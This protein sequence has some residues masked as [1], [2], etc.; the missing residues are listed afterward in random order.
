MDV[1]RTI[2][3]TIFDT[4]RYNRLTERERAGTVYFIGTG[5]LVVASLLIF[6]IRDVT[7]QEMLLE[8]AFNDAAL[9]VPLVLFYVL[10]AGAL[11]LVRVGRLNLGALGMVLAWSAGFGLAGAATGFYD[12]S[13]GLILAET[14]LLA[15]L[16]L[17]T[18]GLVL[19]T[20]LTIALFVFGIRMR[21]ILPVPDNLGGD[22][23]PAP[24]IFLAAIFV[25]LTYVFIRLARLSRE[26]GDLQ[27]SLERTRLSEITSQITRHIS[28]RLGLDEVLNEAVNY[29]ISHYEEIYHAQIFLIDDEGK[30]ARLV[31]S[32]GEAGQKLLALQHSLDVGG[33][34]VIGQ[35]TSA[36]SPVIARAR[37]A[38][39][40]HR[41]NQYLP[42]TRVE[43]A[44]PL[45]IGDKIIGALDLQSKKDVAFGADELPV[46][47]T[48]ADHIAIGIDNARLFEEAAKRVEE[49]Q[50]LVEQ[51]QETLRQV[52]E[53]NRRLT[54]QA[55]SDFMA[56]D[57]S[58]LGLDVDFEQDIVQPNAA[59]TPELEAAVQEDSMI[60]RVVDGR[61]VLVV[62]V[63]VRGAVIG[64]MEFELDADGQL[65]PEDRQLISEVSER[66]GLAAENARLF[67]ESQRIAH[68][69]ALINEVGARLQATVNVEKTLTEAARG[70]QQMLGAGRV[71]IRLGEPPVTN[72]SGKDGR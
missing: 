31:S 54:R 2:L 23:N 60:E 57:L 13:T 11:L 17:G 50:A 56:S 27:A 30:R 32:T 34:S 72:G 9:G 1:L 20:I 69:E 61:R 3:Q 47:Q 45:I 29:V 15:A 28:S 18:P 44:F 41:A 42:D 35:V 5:L 19:G 25:F 40:V 59:W 67:A 63:Q 65:L 7:T 6:F 14:I 51:S 22:I 64:A 46:F 12:V 52:E 36:G 24:Y 10:T 4:S 39:T 26:E 33:Q 8:Q 48:L 53:L 16:L 55:W 43:A 49:N 21:E 66:F 71:S 38:G 58:S 62:P 37:S 70:L 68:R